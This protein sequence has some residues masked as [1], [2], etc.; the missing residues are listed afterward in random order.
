LEGGDITERSFFPGSICPHRK[1]FQKIIHE[2]SILGMEDL[3]RIRRRDRE[4]PP[5]TA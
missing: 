4:E 1:S 3:H 5:V 2:F